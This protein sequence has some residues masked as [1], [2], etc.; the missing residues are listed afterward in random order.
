MRDLTEVR[1]ITGTRLALLNF[2]FSLKLPVKYLQEE[3]IS[4]F[5]LLADIVFICYVAVTGLLLVDL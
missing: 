1:D 2:N 4:G 5:T 3:S